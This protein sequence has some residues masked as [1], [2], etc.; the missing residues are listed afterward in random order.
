MLAEKL[1]LAIE[2]EIN[3]HCNMACSYCPNARSERTEKG[4]MEKETFVELMTQLKSLNYKGR[5]SFHFYN[6]PTLSPNLSEFIQITRSFLENSFIDIFSNGTLLDIDKI[7]NFIDMGVDRFN[8]TE[9][10]KSDLS[11]LKEAL[12]ACSDEQLKTKVSLQSYKTMNL[13]NRGGSLKLKNSHTPP[14][15]TPCLIPYCAMVVTVKGNIVCC[16]EDYFQTHVMGNIHDNHIQEIWSSKKYSD[17]RNA[18]KKGKRSLYP[19]C[20]SCNNNWIIS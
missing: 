8:I 12:E 3:S 9:H 14:L 6:E 15:S 18:L 5:I 4:L 11:K 7:K 13:T 1:P 16:Y 2:I 19:V 20:N 10:I 17:M